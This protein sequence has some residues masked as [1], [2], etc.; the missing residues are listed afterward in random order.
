MLRISRAAMPGDLR[1]CELDWQYSLA[2]SASA[3]F[4]VSWKKR[5]PSLLPTTCRHDGNKAELF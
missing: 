2:W 3:S 5:S 1:L 4:V